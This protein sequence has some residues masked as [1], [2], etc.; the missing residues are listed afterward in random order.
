MHVENL[1]IENVRQ[2]RNASFSFQEGF[3]VLIGENGAGKT[4]ILRSLFVVL[5]SLRQTGKRTGLYEGDIHLGERSLQI[6]ANVRGIE[7]EER[8]LGYQKGFGSR[9]SRFGDG[10][11]L[12]VLYYG[13]NEV[14][15]GNLKNR[16]VRRVT[17][18][19]DRPQATT[20]EEFFYQ[21]GQRPIG[22]PR[23]EERFG[24]SEEIR[25]FVGEVLKKVSPDFTDFY[26]RF[27]PYQCAIVRPY[28]KSNKPVAGEKELAA[29]V[30]RY[31]QENPN[32]LRGIDQRKITLHPSGYVVGDSDSR[33]VTPPLYEF[34]ENLKPIDE[35]GKLSESNVEIRLAPRIVI[36]TSDGELLLSQLSDGQQRVFSLLIDIAR[37][38]SLFG[39]DNIKDTPGII[40]IDE[41]DLHL[42]PRWQR[43]VVPALEDLFP[44]CQFI[45]T[46]HSPFIIQAVDKRRLISPTSQKQGG[47]DDRVTSIEDIIEEIQGIDMPQRGKRAEELSDAAERYFSLL[48]RSSAP[49]WE[50]W[51]AEKA[52]RIATEP[53]ASNPALNALL[54]LEQL[55]SEEQ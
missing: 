54:R 6:E 29:S 8:Y 39:K 38:L 15:T 16:R 51:E 19:D 23:P 30:L 35:K 42:H 3:N 34:L 5:G 24:N 27:E 10:S 20:G 48:R 17:G 11:D 1:R 53:F 44:A 45:A 47:F 9:A 21:A 13:A 14:T 52:Y 4:T 22:N 55:Q 28:D 37:V 40:L 18:D 7:T 36:R 50:L 2:F 12:T 41:I 26:W 43:I 32:N 49:R 25:V 46:T 33:S 31:L